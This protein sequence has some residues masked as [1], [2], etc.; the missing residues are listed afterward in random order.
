[1]CRHIMIIL[2]SAVLCLLNSSD[3]F[4]CTGNNESTWWISG[5]F[6]L[7]S[8]ISFKCLTFS[9]KLCK[10][11]THSMS[12]G[13]LTVMSTN[14]MIWN[15]T[16]CGN[17]YPTRG[18]HIPGDYNLDKHNHTNVMISYLLHIPTKQHRVSPRLMTMSTYE[19]HPNQFPLKIIWVT[20]G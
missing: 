10:R 20:H 1:M 19:W 12:L 2:T 13:S 6:C 11:D 17:L 15:R 5:F 16:A 14:I 4:F 18:H 9:F 7:S 8:Y 3:S